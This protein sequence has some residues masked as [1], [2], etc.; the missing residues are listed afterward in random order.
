M[1]H[2]GG[3]RGVRIDRQNERVSEFLGDTLRHVAAYV[4]MFSRGHNR[5]IRV[6][7]ATAVDQGGL[8]GHDGRH[9]LLSRV[10]G[11]PDGPRLD[12]AKGAKAQYEER[13]GEDL[14]HTSLKVGATKTRERATAALVEAGHEV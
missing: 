4:D 12:E 5:T 10:I 2:L 1:G 8:A 6:S 7:G 11:D 14:H 13:R 3:S 9:D